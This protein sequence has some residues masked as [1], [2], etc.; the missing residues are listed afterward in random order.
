MKCKT[1]SGPLEVLKRCGSIQMRCSQC[2]ETFAIHEVV[3]QLDSHT[4]EILERY[5]A[6][7][8]D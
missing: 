3:D 7:V 1:C 4:E 8:Y 5:N 6:I 2:G